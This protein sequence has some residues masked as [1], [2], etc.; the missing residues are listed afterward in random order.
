M[1]RMSQALRNAFNNVLQYTEAGG[2]ILYRLGTESDKG[3]AISVIYDGTGIHATNL[4]H[5]F[6]RF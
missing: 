5:V 6:D 4:P 1:V 3:L 2:K